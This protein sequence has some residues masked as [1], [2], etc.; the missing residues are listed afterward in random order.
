MTYA[1]KRSGI[2]SLAIIPVLAIVLGLGLLSLHARTRPVQAQVAD[3]D[4]AA[5]IL[6]WYAA[7]NQGDLNAAAAM[8]A[9]NTFFVSSALAGTC[10]L[11]AP[12]HDPASALPSL[13][14][15][16][17]GNSHGCLTVTSIQVDGSIVTGRTEVRNDALR[18]RG[19]ER[20]IT[21]FMAEVRDGKIVSLFQRADQGDTLTAL[22]GA[23]AAGTAQAGTPIPTPNS[24]CG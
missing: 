20:S 5:V 23:I 24:V 6:N 7:R 12:C 21:A 22:N 13:Q 18:S 8:F 4:R 16:D 2:R 14:A 15:S 3:P 10:S 19:V 1:M 9:D 17:A 11:Q